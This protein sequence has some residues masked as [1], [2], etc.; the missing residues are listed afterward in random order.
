MNTLAQQNAQPVALPQSVERVLATTDDRTLTFLRVSLGLLLFPHGAQHLLGWFGGYGFAGTYQWMTADLGHPGIAA[1]LA[2]FAEFFGSLGLMVGLFSRV[3]ALGMIGIML[4]AISFHWE[5]GFFI[6]W[7]G[8]LP[9]G[10]EGFEY[11]LLVIVMAVVVFVKGSGA[12]SL[13]RWI[14]RS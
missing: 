4:G 3:A 12:V 5:N 13:D 11:H 6:N 2:I 1:A 8:A 7:F 10:A 9:A 14:T